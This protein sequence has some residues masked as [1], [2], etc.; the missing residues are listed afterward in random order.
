[1]QVRFEHLNTW[2]KQVNRN[3]TSNNEEN[4][5]AKTLK[6]TKGKKRNTKLK[7]NVL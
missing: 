2:L 3:Y 1:M 5:P 7:P 6:E 4:K